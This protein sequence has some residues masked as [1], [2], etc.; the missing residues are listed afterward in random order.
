M[1][2]IFGHA[3][4]KEKKNYQHDMSTYVIISSQRDPMT[5][6]PSD[7]GGSL[8]SSME[9]RAFNSVLG[10]NFSR[11]AEGAVPNFLP[12]GYITFKSRSPKT[13]IQEVERKNEEEENDEKKE[14]RKEGK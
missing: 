9:K 2:N 12:T 4:M 1:R 14:N 7:H 6:I 8:T 10:T 3:P 13:N 11:G 5:Y